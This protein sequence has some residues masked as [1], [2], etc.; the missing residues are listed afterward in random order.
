MYCCYCKI[1]HE[2]EE[3]TK[4]GNYCHRTHK[5]KEGN[6]VACDLFD[7][8]HFFYCK[9]L[10]R[11][12]DM[13]VCMHINKKQAEKSAKHKQLY[14][15]CINC[16]QKEEIIELHRGIRSEVPI[17]IKRQQKDVPEPIIERKQP[18]LMPKEKPILILKQKKPLLL[19]KRGAT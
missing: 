18:I 13:V 6:E 9:K 16:K 12:Q 10:Q 14:S 3:R 19:I 1:Y 8:N 2:S 15:D 4:F 5:V 7:L 17:L 11:R